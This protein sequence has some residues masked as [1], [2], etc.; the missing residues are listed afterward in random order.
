MLVLIA[1]LGAI[2]TNAI[3]EVGRM[4]ML[5][6]EVMRWTYLCICRR[7]LPAPW[8]V[9]LKQMYFIGVSSIPVVITTGAFTGMVLAYESYF[10]LSKLGVTSWMGP[11]V[12]NSLVLQLGPVLT[13]VMLAGRVGG[14]MTAELGTMAVTEQLDALR[15]MGTDPVRYLVVPRVISATF[16]APILT[17][18]A[19][20]V[21]ILAGFGLAVY[22]QGVD[23]HY[24]WQHTK[25]FLVWY[26]FLTGM[27]KAA[28]FGGSM[29]LICCYKGINTRGGAEGV[30]RST[31]EANVACCISV[32]MLNLFLTMVMY[33]FDPFR[34]V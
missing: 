7:Q 18:F 17:A 24:M 13:G 33:V 12:A 9:I 23:G 32:L 16:L 19:F 26:D 29:A 10:Q 15:T 22:G 1:Q 27:T 25:E 4:G 8:K 31:T 14:A 5:L 28:V 6:S 21:G 30:G 20:V 11:L 2:F 3:A 34:S